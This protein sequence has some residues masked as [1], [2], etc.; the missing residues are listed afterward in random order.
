[1]SRH[2]ASRLLARLATRPL[3]CQQ[4]QSRS[5][6]IHEYQVPHTPALALFFFF[7]FL[8]CSDFLPHM[9]FI[10]PFILL[11]QGAALM[12]K[13]GVNVPKGVVVSSTKEIAGVLKEQ[14]P[15]DAE[16][17][18]SYPPLLPIRILSGSNRFQS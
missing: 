8:I 17:A 10:F 14:F 18:L 6:N 3:P 16:V 7:F 1:M 13:F 9:M 4:Q 5:L 12:S 2:A 15:D 11:F